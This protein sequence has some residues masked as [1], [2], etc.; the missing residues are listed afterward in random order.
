MDFFLLLNAGLNSVIE[1]VL[2][3]TLFCLVPA[4]IIA[5]AMAALVPKNLLLPY[6]GK[7][8][9]K[10]VS[11][12]IAIGSGLLLAVCSCTVLPLFAGIRKS[13][14]GLGPALAFLYTAP[15]TNIIAILYTGSLIGWD[16]AGARIFFSILFAVTIGLMISKWLPDKSNDQVDLMEKMTPAEAKKEIKRLVLL[17]LGLVA[18]LLVGT[19]LEDSLTKYVI[20]FALVL[21]TVVIT[22]F[23]FSIIEIKSWWTETWQF[24]KLIVP[25]LLVGVFV[26]GIIGFLIPKEL[27]AGFFGNNSLFAISIPV[28][29]GIFVYFPTLVEV[30][31]AKLF[32]DLG[33]A[34]GP[35][36]AYLL[37]DPVIS[38]ASILVIRQIMGTKRT[39]VYAGLIFV[40]SVAAGWLFGNFLS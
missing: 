9:S 3:H 8:S 29:F 10:W 26:A 20:I 19:R 11:Y 15:A 5:G 17:F 24:T 22:K 23:F 30:P 25:L 18:I 31:M 37:A 12:P 40:F 14:A 21:Y 38:L 32:L 39:I 1:Y 28:L 36:L 35:L 16:I 2:A 13:G 27:I 34:K 4:F 6:L 33:M 7:N